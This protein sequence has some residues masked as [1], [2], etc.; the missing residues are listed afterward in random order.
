SWM[1]L[2][3]PGTGDDTAP[4]K[5]A[6]DQDG[7]NG[8]LN[9]SSDKVVV[10][11][12]VY[13]LEEENHQLYLSSQPLDGADR[14]VERGPLAFTISDGARIAELSLAKL[15]A[16]NLMAVVKIARGNE[17]DFYC[18]TFIAPP[19]G[20]VRGHYGCHQ[21]RF[22]TTR[23]P[24]SILAVGGKHYGGSVFIVLGY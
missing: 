14:K 16:K 9:Q 1:L 18:L 12:I 7:K 20:H 8:R 17:F 3:S 23:D 2:A 24:L 6:A 22:F 4:G 11:E 19:G 5:K 15:G 21:A 10:K 13:C